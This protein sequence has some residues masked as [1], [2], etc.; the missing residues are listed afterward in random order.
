MEH[1]EILTRAQTRAQNNQ[2][3]YAGAVTPQE[4]WVLLESDDFALVDVRSSAE[5][6]FVGVP[7]G[8]LLIEYKIFPGMRINGEFLAQLAASIPKERKVLFLCRSGARSHE[9]ALVAHQAGYTA[10]NILEGFEG[11]LDE[12]CHRNTINGWKKQGLPWKQS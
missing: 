2:L 9:A 7:D 4:A 8:A 1:N 5:W 12:E 6:Q 10:Y 11:D 3:P